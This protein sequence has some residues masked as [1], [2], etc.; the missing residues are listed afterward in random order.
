MSF[1]LADDGTGITGAVIKKEDLSKKTGDSK[2]TEY[3]LKGSPSDRPA[4]LMVTATS[5]NNAYN[6]LCNEAVPVSL[7]QPFSKGSGIT[8]TLRTTAKYQDTDATTKCCNDPVFVPI[9]VA[10]KVRALQSDLTSESVILTNQDS[11]VIR[12]LNLV[13]QAGLSSLLKGATDIAA[14]MS[15]D[16]DAV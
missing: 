11:E 8:L 12:V 4:T 6:T 14:Y 10:V 3:F 15:D 5:I 13:K 1:T 7:Q 2:H 9:E 16:P